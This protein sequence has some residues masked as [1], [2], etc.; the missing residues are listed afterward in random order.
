MKREQEDRLT[1]K[2]AAAL[3]GCPLKVESLRTAIN[4]GKLPG[5]KYGN[6]W[7][8]TREDLIYYLENRKIGRPKKDD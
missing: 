2:E 6:T 3:P 1:L 8:I 7:T 4:R 5:R